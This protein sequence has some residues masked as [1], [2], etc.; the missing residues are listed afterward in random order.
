MSSG[1]FAYHLLEDCRVKHAYNVILSIQKL[2][3]LTED[4]AIYYIKQVMRD[5]MNPHLRSYI[6]VM[7]GVWVCDHVENLF[8]ISWRIGLFFMEK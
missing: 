5:P 1:G 4:Y 8:E 6:R 3:T 7:D 2:N